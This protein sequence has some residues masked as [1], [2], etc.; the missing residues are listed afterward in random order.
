MSGRARMGWI[1]LLSLAGL[2]VSGYLAYAYL[3]EASVACLGGSSDCDA[4]KASPYAWLGPVPIPLLGLAGYA[5]TLLLSALWFRLGE[6]GRETASLLIFGV[7]LVGVLF[8]SYLTYLEFFVIH[9]LCHWCLASALIMLLV[10]GASCLDIV[11]RRADARS[12]RTRP[13]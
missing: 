1:A 6:A 12:G 10:F 9:A 8:S 13:G 11:A 4:V 3:G 7:S 2:G 5:A